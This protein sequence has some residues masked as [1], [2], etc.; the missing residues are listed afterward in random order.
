MM[1]KPPSF[2]NINC[3]QYCIHISWVTRKDA[4]CTKHEIDLNTAH[5]VFV[6]RICDDFKD[7]EYE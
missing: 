6:A 2:R 4:W 7:E 1:S 3:C 5:E